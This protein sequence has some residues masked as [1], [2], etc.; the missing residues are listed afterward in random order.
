MNGREE[1]IT[2]KGDQG[3]LK[4]MTIL[5]DRSIPNEVVI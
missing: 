4:S 5:G 1:N 2:Y 3:K